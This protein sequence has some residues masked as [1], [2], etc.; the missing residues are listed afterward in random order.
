MTGDC[1]IVRGDNIFCGLLITSPSPL[2]EEVKPHSLWPV[3][4]RIRT[5]RLCVCVCA[6][7]RTRTCIREMGTGSLERHKTPKEKSLVTVQCVCFSVNV[8]G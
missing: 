1:G 7:V 8:N 6:C 3:K 4:Q 5:L 2:L